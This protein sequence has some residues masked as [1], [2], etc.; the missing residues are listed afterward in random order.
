[1]VHR[2]RAADGT[3]SGTTDLGGRLRSHPAA[4]SWGPG[5][6]DVFPR[7]TDN[8]VWHRSFSAGRWS[9]WASLGGQLASG[10]GATASGDDVTVI[11]RSPNGALY[12]R[13]RPAVRRRRGVVGASAVSPPDGTGTC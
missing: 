13:T 1:M 9:G 4:V 2:V 8:A 3:W 7:G 5:R 11:G 12:Q 10:P 6:L